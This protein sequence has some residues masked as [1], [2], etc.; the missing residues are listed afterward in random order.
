GPDAV[1]GVGRQDDE[2]AAGQ[3]AGGGLDALVTALGLG[4]VVH[5]HVP[6]PP[7]R[8]AAGMTSLPAM[9]LL[10]RRVLLVLALLVHLA[11][12]YAPQVPG[13]GPAA[14]PGADKVA[15]LGVF[16]LVVL[17]ALR[18]GLP[19][20]WV[21]PLALAHAVLSELVQHA[22]LPGRSGDVWDTV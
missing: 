11:V 4:A 21:V 16:A 20:R 13:G 10:V 3:G 22:V 2:P 15:H 1:D 19:A 7:T 14:V 8:T 5:A 9:T 17:L 6:D 18:A 12:L